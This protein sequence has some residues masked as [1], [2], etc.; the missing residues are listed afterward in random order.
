MRLEFR[1]DRRG[2]WK[3]QVFI[4]DEEA[5]REIRRVH[6]IR[7]R[8]GYSLVRAYPEGWCL[9]WRGRGF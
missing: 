8:H 9:P 4:R 2:G 3:R 1:T 5:L 6:R 7:E